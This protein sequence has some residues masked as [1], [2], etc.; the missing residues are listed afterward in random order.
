MDGHSHDAHGIA[1]YAMGHSQVALFT[2]IAAHLVRYTDL[3][4]IRKFFK[5]RECNKPEISHKQAE[6]PTL[7][8]TPYTASID[9]SLLKN[10]AFMEYFDQIDLK[11]TPKPLTSEQ[12]KSYL[13][14]L[15]QQ[16]DAPHNPRLI[17]KAM[18][19]LKFL[20]II[21][22]LVH[23]TPRIAQVLLRDWKHYNIL[24]LNKTSRVYYQVA[25]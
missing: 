6:V 10:L 20:C 4:Q 22:D 8:V 23:V 14:G 2:P 9:C 18:E 5:E 16:N 7:Q 13:L 17:R 21:K 25:S 1:S 3:I 11:A 15:V 19:R 24:N 12:I